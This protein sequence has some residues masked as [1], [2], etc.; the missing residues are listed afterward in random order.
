VTGYSFALGIDEAHR[1]GIV[2]VDDVAVMSDEPEPLAEAGPPVEEVDT[3][4]GGLCPGAFTLPLGVIVVL[5]SRK[6]RGGTGP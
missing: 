3:P 6:R 2:W 5:L 4:G 1:E